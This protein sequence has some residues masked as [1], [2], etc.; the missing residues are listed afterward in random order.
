MS[1]VPLVVS[2]RK[3]LRPLTWLA[4]EEV[5]EEEASRTQDTELALIPVDKGWLRRSDWA[6]VLRRVIPFNGGE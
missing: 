4:V 3:S 5:D 2:L 1:R 6:R